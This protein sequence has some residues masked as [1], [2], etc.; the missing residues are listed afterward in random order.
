[1]NGILTTFTQSA[2]TLTYLRL[3]QKPE[4]SEA[5]VFAKPMR[6]ISLILFGLLLLA[7][8]SNAVRAQ[9]GVATQSYTWSMHRAFLPYQLC[10]MYMTLRAAGHRFATSGGDPPGG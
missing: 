9:E 8:Q 6:K 4:A 7:G 2:W 10:W 1:L 5:I 3:K